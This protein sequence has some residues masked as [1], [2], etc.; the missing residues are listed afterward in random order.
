MQRYYLARGVM[1]PHQGPSYLMLATPYAFA[2][3]EIWFVENWFWEIGRGNIH[4][5]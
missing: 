1:T 5:L 3:S 4:A 2:N